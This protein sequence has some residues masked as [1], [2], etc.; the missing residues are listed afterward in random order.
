MSE[1]ERER[2]K[3]EMNV[4]IIKCKKKEFYNILWKF[5]EK[6]GYRKEKG[7]GRREEKER[8]EKKG[9]KEEGE[10]KGK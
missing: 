5:M 1:R 4:A 3:R 9:R 2:E 6:G 8:E 10:R 7:R